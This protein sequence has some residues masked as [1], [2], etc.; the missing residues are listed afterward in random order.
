M[1]A[2]RKIYNDMPETID[3]PEEIQHKKVELIFIIDEKKILKNSQSNKRI[4]GLL[5]GKIS[6]S[7][8][9]NEPLE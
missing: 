7:D 2:L 8:D 9:F 5:K 4:P 6:I 3:I 1:N